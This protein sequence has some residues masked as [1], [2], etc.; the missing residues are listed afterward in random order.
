MTVY[1]LHRAAR[2]AGDFTGPMLAGGRWNPIGLPMLYTA[3]HLSLGC[4]EVLVHVDQGQ[5]PRDYVWSKADL[6][7]PPATLSVDNRPSV[8]DCQ[9]QGGAW[10]RGGRQRPSVCRRP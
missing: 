1:R 2:A 6:G 5:I 8:S 4:L 9:E 10:I 7:E 3:E